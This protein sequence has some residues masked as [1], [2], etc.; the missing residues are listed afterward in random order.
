MSNLKPLVHRILEDYELPWH[1]THGVAHWARVLENGLWLAKETGANLEVVQLFAVFHDCRRVNEGRDQ[2]H[3]QRGA[4]LAAALRGE[5]FTLSD[6][7]FESLYEACVRH[8]DGS[9]DGN[10]TVQTCW[11]AD[12]LDLGRVCICPEPGRLCT[13]TAK[14]IIKWADKRAC[15]EMVP[16]LVKTQWGIDVKWRSG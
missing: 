6:N 12:R 3:G 4:E 13:P 7:D 14:R 15:L 8:T 2:G 1:G 5:W 10:I 11:D 16:E 9:T